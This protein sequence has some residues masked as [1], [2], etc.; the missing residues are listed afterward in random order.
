[1]GSLLGG[2]GISTFGSRQTLRIAS[3]AA[4]V[5]AVAYLI[6]YYCYVQV[7]RCRRKKQFDRR[8]KQEREEMLSTFKMIHV[9]FNHIWD[10]GQLNFLLTFFLRM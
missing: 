1:L 7:H 3:V 5:L 2:W 6:F 9:V 10:Y 4:A 8:A